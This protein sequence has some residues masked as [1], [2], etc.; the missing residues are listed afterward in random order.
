MYTHIHTCVHM[1]TFFKMCCLTQ[2]YLKIK[3]TCRSLEDQNKKEGCSSTVCFITL[4]WKKK[5]KGILWIES[6]D[7]IN[8]YKFSQL[9]WMTRRV[10]SVTELFHRHLV[11]PY[12]LTSVCAVK[13]T[14]NAEPLPLCGPWQRMQWSTSET[15][16]YTTVANADFNHAYSILTMA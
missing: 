7:R 6:K 1:N 5:F 11:E 9:N 8:I 12:P 15:N 10:T 3:K 2:R 4:G 14:R 16:Y 13:A